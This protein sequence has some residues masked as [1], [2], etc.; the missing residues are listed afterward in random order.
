MRI[1]LVLLCIA[2]LLASCSSNQD[3]RT[4]SR[5]LPG[6]PP[7]RPRLPRPCCMSTELTPGAGGA[8]SPSI[9]GSL[10][11]APGKIPTRST[12]WS[13]GERTGAIRSWALPRDAPD[14]H[15]YGARPVCSWNT[16]ARCG[17]DDR[18]RGPRRQKLPVA[19]G[20]QGLSGPNSNTF[21]AWI[22]RQVPELGLDCL[23]PP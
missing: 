5:D 17:R 4:A 14:R 9:P 3:W 6:S 1:R 7:I 18:G 10:P 21:V 11:N 15:W 8:G 12:M 13:A 22:G 2:V 20:I 23:F 19:N 16:G